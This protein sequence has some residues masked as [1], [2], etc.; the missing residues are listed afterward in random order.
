MHQDV[1]FTWTAPASATKVLKDWYSQSVPAWPCIW[2]FGSVSGYGLLGATSIFM[3]ANPSKATHH[4]RGQEP[5]T[6][7]HSQVGTEPKSATGVWS[8]ASGDHTG[9][10][11]SARGASSHSTCNAMPTT[12]GSQSA[13][14]KGS[15]SHRRARAPPPGGGGHALSSGSAL[16]HRNY[17]RHGS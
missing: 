10:Q 16:R 4:R 2:T 6:L 8:R 14:P 17:S 13:P 5:C 12:R 9:R 3:H 15:S 1:T 7:R 11:E